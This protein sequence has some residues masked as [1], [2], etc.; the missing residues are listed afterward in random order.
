[1]ASEI[2]RM[3]IS[4]L[5]VGAVATL[6]A[7]ALAATAAA[8]ASAAAATS[9]PSTAFA[10]SA[11]GTDGG[12]LL[13]GTP[14]RVLDAA[15]RVSNLL[16]RPI[17]VILQAA[18]IENASNGN[19]DYDTVRVSRAG[20][21]L[22]LA[23]SVI[24]LGPHTSRPVPFTVDVPP[25]ASGASH[26]AGIV[27]VNAADL[28]T[29]TR[30]STGQRHTFTF[31]RISR[32]ALPITIRLPGPLSRSLALNSAH[33]AVRPAGSQLVL[34]VGVSGTELIDETHINLRVL[35]GRRTI[36]SYASTLGQLFPDAPLNYHIPWD[37]ELRDGT[38]HVTGSIRP[39]GASAVNIN[40]TIK[41]SRADAAQATHDA[42][43]TTRP[44]A[45]NIPPWIWLTLA[46]AAA[47]LIALSASVWKLTRRSMRPA[48]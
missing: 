38:Y 23:A 30:S 21:W 35:R 13:R 3:T 33:L 8:P 40:R 9:P 4:R 17:T 16:G 32:Q 27:A 11:V 41:V 20:R 46:L 26:Y 18:D 39:E 7:L 19:A 29:A 42:A 48:N 31:Y 25:T 2:N 37:G 45:S 14:G 5:R 44:G 22:H 6:A 15:V 12:F 43:A 34:G 36:F 28:A 1:M 24:R 10:L 47:L